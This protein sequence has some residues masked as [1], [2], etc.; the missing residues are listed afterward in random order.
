M[1]GLRKE[2]FAI[3]LRIGRMKVEVT[4]LREETVRLEEVVMYRNKVID[5]RAML[6][7]IQSKVYQNLTSDA[8]ITA[9]AE[10]FGVTEAELDRMEVTM[11]RLEHIL[12]HKKRH[13]Q[14]SSTT[15]KPETVKLPK[16]DLP[17]FD[18]KAE[19]WLS[20]RDLFTA[21]VV[22]NN[23]LSSVFKMSYLKSSLKGEAAHQIRNHA[24]LD[25]HFDAA[26]ADVVKRY[27]NEREIVFS[28]LRRIFQA[29]QVSGDSAQSLQ[30]LLDT[31]MEALRSL[32]VK[33]TASFAR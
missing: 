21:I 30:R 18:G 9:H 20:F 22:D 31:V 1:E 6:E 24:V 11:G 5:F 17:T 23:T 3:N 12:V 27:E 19:D 26:W 28:L 33:S 7:S 32:K 14:E 8:E 13:Q 25:G 4:H 10:G 15:P 2:V 16:V 29:K